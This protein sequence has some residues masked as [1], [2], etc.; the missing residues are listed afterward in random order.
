MFPFGQA[1]IWKLK[2]FRWILGRTPISSLPTR[3]QIKFLFPP[4]A[5]TYSTEPK[6]TLKND[7]TNKGVRSFLAR[8]FAAAELPVNLKRGGAENA[9]EAAQARV[10]VV[11]EV[12]SPWSTGTAGL[13]NLVHYGK[14]LG[15]GRV[16]KILS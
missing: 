6:T 16:P 15:V 5:K 9:E 10:L 7:K 13:C 11:D 2:R 4:P 1:L 3:R 14:R 8:R 12:M